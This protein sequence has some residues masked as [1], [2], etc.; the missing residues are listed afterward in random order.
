MTPHFAVDEWR[1]KDGTPYPEK[2]IDDRLRV[3]CAQLEII[4]HACGDRVITILSGYRTP[5]YNAAIDGADNSQHCHGRAA[6]I[7]VEGMAPSDVHKMILFLFEAGKIEIGG[8]GIY[9][10]WCHLDI[11]PRPASGHLARWSG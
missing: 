6:D 5:S 4:R 8:L 9:S 7:R 10:G 2:W 3:L 11:R 1:C